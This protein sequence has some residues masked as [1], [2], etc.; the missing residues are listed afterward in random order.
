MV[1]EITDRSIYKRLYSIRQ[2]YKK[3]IA[4][5]FTQQDIEVPVKECHLL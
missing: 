3:Q 2:Y 4:N 5:T 1:Q